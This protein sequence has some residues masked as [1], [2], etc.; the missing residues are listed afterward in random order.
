VSQLELLAENDFDSLGK[1]ITSGSTPD[2][3]RFG[4][5]TGEENESFSLLRNARIFGGLLRDQEDG[6]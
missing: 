1:A 3:F 5:M 4:I 6:R 2:A